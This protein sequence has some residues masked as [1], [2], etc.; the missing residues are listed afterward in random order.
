MD[1]N[2]RQ[3]GSQAEQIAQEY[4]RG[5]GYRIM[6]ANWQFGHL[7][8]DIIA[9]DQDELVIVEVKSRYGTGFS[10]PTEA[11]SEKKMLQVIQAADAWIIQ[12]DW[13]KDARFDLITVVFTGPD[14]FELEHYE[15]AFNSQL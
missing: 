14:E 1:K 8:L 9:Q 10:H 4:L 5:K 12:S 15:E 13:D 3:K 11:I 6:D 2:T 7:E